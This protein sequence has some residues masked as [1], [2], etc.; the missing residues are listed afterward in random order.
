M[1]VYI[2]PNPRHHMAQTTALV[3]D[4]MVFLNEKFESKWIMW[5]NY[6]LTLAFLFLIA[7][8]SREPVVVVGRTRGDCSTLRS[9]EG[10]VAGTGEHAG[11]L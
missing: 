9:L 6:I 10:A 1:Y 2:H 4:S 5:H 3:G 7:R 8:G 11:L